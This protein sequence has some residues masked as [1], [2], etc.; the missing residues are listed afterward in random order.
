M[1]HDHTL[2]T[3]NLE[4]SSYLNIS[5]DLISD[6]V[7]L[8]NESS[9]INHEHLVGFGKYCK[10]LTILESIANQQH[11]TKYC[12]RSCNAV[13]S[14]IV[15]KRYEEIQSSIRSYSSANQNISREIEKNNEY[16]Q[17]LS[18][19]IN[20]NQSTIGAYK[21]KI[22]DLSEEGKIYRSY[23]YPFEIK[24]QQL[25]Q[26]IENELQII[27]DLE[28]K[29]DNNRGEVTEKLQLI[30]ASSQELSFLKLH[31]VAPIFDVR[32]YEQA[33]VY[34]FNGYRISYQP[35]KKDNLFWPEINTSWY[36][37]SLL[38]TSLRNK[39]KLSLII[40]MKMN[41][42]L[43]IFKNN[44]VLESFS[45]NDTLSITL[46]PLLRNS[47]L[48]IRYNCANYAYDYD[49]E[50][51]QDKNEKGNVNQNEILYLL[52]DDEA[53]GTVQYYRLWYL[54]AAYV[55]STAIDMKREDVIDG[56]LLSTLRAA[57]KN[58][59]R[60]ELYEEDEEYHAAMTS[61]VG[62]DAAPEA[63]LVHEVLA[64]LHRLAA[65]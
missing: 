65:H 22:K 18:D 16:Y 15:E 24:N 46:Q 31:S 64:S 40:N 41:Y 9:Q 32:F 54:F 13:L 58:E 36:I 47:I 29:I 27:K 53:V 26:D 35:I 14:E 1:Y 21:D 4:E 30:K 59:C 50:R 52:G 44:N 42:K 38:L 63:E 8:S 3:C 5:E 25:T 6:S 55:V 2:F 34:V 10:K 56:R 62:L 39:E 7:Y 23:Y 37:A 51:M 57:L 60:S 19:I 49:D 11:H 43:K 12:C 48:L 28:F 20:N 45:S 33:V 61:A 17:K